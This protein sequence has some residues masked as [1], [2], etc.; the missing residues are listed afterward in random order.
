V[1]TAHVIIYTAVFSHIV[2]VRPKLVQQ[3]M[4]NSPDKGDTLTNIQI[5]LPQNSL[6]STAH[7]AHCWSLR[8]AAAVTSVCCRHSRL[9]FKFLQPALSEVTNIYTLPFSRSVW[10]TY[11]AAAAVL[12][13]AWYATARL[14]RWA[15]PKRTGPPVAFVDTAM[16]SLAIVCSEGEKRFN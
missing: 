5:K 13:V 9:S 10:A 4:P 12:T 11:V 3:T 7:C 15:N 1:S 6:F 16:N 2:E 8:F 14:E